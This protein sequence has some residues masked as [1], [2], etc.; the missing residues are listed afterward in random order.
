MPSDTVAN[1][2]GVEPLLLRSADV[3]RLL[4]ISARQFRRLDASGQVPQAIRVG[5]SKRWRVDELRSWCAS[6]CPARVRWQQR[7]FGAVA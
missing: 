4:G 6:G 1:V 3:A 5:A 7:Q 2:V